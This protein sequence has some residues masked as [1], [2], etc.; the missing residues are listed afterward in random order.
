MPFQLTLTDKKNSKIFRTL[1]VPDRSTFADFE[2]LIFIAFDNSHMES[3]F[4]T[5]TKS[6]GKTIR[7]VFIGAD[8]D[9]D[10]ST[11]ADELLDDEE[12][13]LNDWFKQEGDVATYEVPSLGMALSMTVDKILPN[14][15][16]QPCPSCIAGK[17][18]LHSGKPAFIDLHEITEEMQMMN[19]LD[20]EVFEELLNDEDLL[21]LLKE[22]GDI[23]ELLDLFEDEPDYEGLLEVATALKNAKPW[24]Y[25]ND[26]EI[27]VIEDPATQDLIFVS[28]LG[29]AGQEFGLALYLNEQGYKTLD[30]M[31][32]EAIPSKEFF[33]NL[34]S[35]TI[36]FVDR[37]ELS[38][39][40]YRIIKDAGFSYRGKKNWIQFRT[41][42]PG[43]F[44]WLPDEDG[45]ETLKLA[46]AITL[47]HIELIKNGWTYPNLPENHFPFYKADVQKGEWELKIIEIPPVQKN[48]THE[49]YLDLPKGL[50]QKLRTTKKAAHEIEFDLVYLDR[51]IQES[52]DERPFYPLL[53]I[54]VDK[55]TGMVIFHDMIP[56]PKE[57]GL[58]Q[59]AFVQLLDTIPFKPKAIHVTKEMADYLKPVAQLT[60]NTLKTSTLPAIRH[61]QQE[62]D[63]GP[64]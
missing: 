27:F 18:N 21:E 10:L 28:V 43:Q 30:A 17:G 51:A 1:I 2:D 15:L 6:Q 16:S 35:L 3:A 56:Y 25:M 57:P 4:F 31:L 38:K 12:E 26:N 22:G 47:E 24:Q 55:K 40:D 48:R 50:V 14:V 7:P 54:A 46:A 64:F 19:A 29:A 11:I 52:P 63:N 60:G 39:E 8:M 44:P 34:E 45:T 61:F 37:D 53:A 5:I 41:Y 9:G 13:L 33:Y 32:S 20:A 62:F 58:A 36:S 23:G 49:I 42:D 59:A